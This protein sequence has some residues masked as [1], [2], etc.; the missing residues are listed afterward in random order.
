MGL[1]RR[2]SKSGKKGIWWIS[3]MEGGRQIRVSSGSTNKQFAEKL[4][5]RRKADVLD[6]RWNLPRSHSPQLGAWSVQFLKSVEHYKTRSRYQSSINNILH[7]FGTQIRLAAIT[8]ERIFAFQ[9]KRLESAGKATVNR[10]V[11][12]LSSLFSRAKK[13][14][15]IQQ[16][17]CRDVGKLN[18]RRDRRVAQPFSYDDEERIKQV[19]PVWLS[20]LITILAD[21]GL[22][23]REALSLNWSDIELDLEPARIIVR[24]SKTAAG[25]RN[26]WL[27]EHCREVVSNWRSTLAQSSPYVF[28]SIRVKG[29]HVIGYRKAWEKALADAGIFGKRMHDWRA[30]FASRANAAHAT[31][32]TLAHLLGHSS[33]TVL[34]TYAKP[35]DEHTRAVIQAMDTAR[36]SLKP[37]ISLI[38]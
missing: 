34:P 10:D 2:N 38:Q 32:L 11:A 7:H 6:G 14:R 35:L 26:A 8:P 17:P 30:T 27:T 37:T 21:T 4:L 20:V 36:A 25:I 5:T 12:T 23:V 31:S 1:F 18:E 22:R 16:N 13:L 15:L 29:A 19:C 3:Y 28:P 24:T 33:T 9:Q